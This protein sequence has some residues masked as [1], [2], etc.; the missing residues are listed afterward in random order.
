MRQL[1]VLTNISL[2]GF[3]EAPGGDISSFTNDFPAFSSDSS[4]AVE[5]VLL[6]RKTYDMMTFWATPQAYELQPEIARYMNDT[7]KVVVTRNPAFQPGWK[8][9]SVIN[10]D[11]TA[12]IAQLK[13]QSGGSIIMFGSNTLCVSLLQAGLID[14]LQILVNPLA[15]GAG[16]SLF[17]GLPHKFAFNLVRTHAFPSGTVSLT[18]SPVR[19]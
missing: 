15:F 5:T 18:Y 13:Q 8:N 11:V 2:D 3:Y 6:G 9:V 17:N 12:R 1:T 19:P 7:L 10:T 14:E 4:A 16:T